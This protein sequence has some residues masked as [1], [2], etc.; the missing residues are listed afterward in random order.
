MTR[1]KQKPLLSP[2]KLKSTW[3]FHRDKAIP[4]SIEAKRRAFK[5]KLLVVSRAISRHQLLAIELV[6]VLGCLLPP[7]FIVVIAIL[8]T[9]FLVHTAGDLLFTLLVPGLAVV[10]ASLVPVLVNPIHALLSLL[11]LFANT[12]V[13]YLNLEAEYLALVFFIVYIG[14]LAI[15]FLFVIMLLN[16]KELMHKHGIAQYCR[17]LYNGLAVGAALLFLRLT[18][19]LTVGLYKLMLLSTDPLHLYP[20]TFEALKAYITTDILALQA[21]YTKHAALFLMITAILVESMLGAIIVAAMTANAGKSERKAAVLSP[22]KGATRIKAV[23]NSPLSW[24]RWL[25]GYGE[26]A[27]IIVRVPDDLKAELAAAA[28]KKAGL[29]E[30]LEAAVQ[31][32]LEVAE[33]TYKL[34]CSFST[35]LTVVFFVTLIATLWTCFNIHN[36]EKKLTFNAVLK[37]TGHF[38]W[39]YLS[40]Y[41]AYCIIF[42]PTTASA[43]KALLFSALVFVT[44][45]YFYVQLL[46]SWLRSENGEGAE[47][48]CQPP[49]VT[50]DTATFTPLPLSRFNQITSDPVVTVGLITLLMLV[51]TYSVFFFFYVGG[52]YTPV[53]PN[54]TANDDVCYA[55]SQ[56]AEA[57]SITL[58]SFTIPP[59]NYLLNYSLTGIT[60]LAY[61]GHGLPPVGDWMWS[62]YYRLIIV[63]ISQCCD[64][65]SSA[66][67]LY[68]APHLLPDELWSVVADCIRAKEVAETEAQLPC[69]LFSE[70]GALIGAIINIPAVKTFLQGVAFVATCHFSLFG[71]NNPYANGGTHDQATPRTPEASNTESTTSNPPA[72]P[73]PKPT[74]I[75]KGPIIHSSAPAGRKQLGCLRPTRR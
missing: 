62:E 9:F 43:A 67:L 25:L 10:A 63:T 71:F 35:A 55:Y 27:P 50:P 14:A 15:L 12:I 75:K 1:R 39:P 20:S 58:V 11:A 42:F 47:G 51:W 30:K 69:T 72:Q 18:T 23:K 64:F 2:A 54:V 68:P 49:T 31:Y 29:L 32:K 48:H 73:T 26:N 44:T 6:L 74:L 66:R 17:A 45:L 61:I 34:S 3:R 16:V 36:R 53:M 46:L 22:K 38:W 40:Y 52:V 28:D 59:V 5:A 4:Q 13:I 60:W 21:L 8:E 65:Q 33:Y 57:P 70:L 19:N 41:V 7:L 24:L 37:N 56:W